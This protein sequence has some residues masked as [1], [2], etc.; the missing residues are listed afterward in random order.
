MKAIFELDLSDVKSK[1][2]L[3]CSLKYASEI[4]SLISLSLRTKTI[5]QDDDKVFDYSE[6]LSRIKERLDEGSDHI[7][8]GGVK[9]FY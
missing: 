9:M 7:L 1:S 5:V 2:E 8:A 3:H 4:V 6:E